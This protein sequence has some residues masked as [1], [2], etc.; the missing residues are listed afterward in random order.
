[1]QKFVV[2]K[3]K[4]APIAPSSS[5][6]LQ[7]KPVVSSAENTVPQNASTAKLSSAD[8]TAAVCK[9]DVTT[10]QPAIKPAAS[11]PPS[12]VP[13]SHVKMS[14]YLKKKRN[15][16]RKKTTH[17]NFVH[18]NVK[19]I[20]KRNKNRFYQ[21]DETLKWL[22]TSHTIT[23]N[24]TVAHSGR[25]I[26][27]IHSKRHEFYDYL[28]FCFCFIDARTPL[29]VQVLAIIIDGAVFFYCS[30]LI[31]RKFIFHLNWNWFFFHWANAK[32]S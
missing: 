14:G 29:L 27:L 4:S 6:P 12:A 31:V 25:T 23:T 2:K 10:K 20:I 13:V 32:K 22:L 5:Q 9:S 7:P 3:S 17:T 28:Y 26:T 11:S 19:H 30:F 15:V 24:P 8:E 18:P 16:R 21:N 1:M